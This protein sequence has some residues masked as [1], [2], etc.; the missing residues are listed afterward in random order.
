[1]NHRRVLVLGLGNVL[2]G[3]DGAG[4]AAVHRLLHEYELPDGVD[5]LDG[6]TLGMSLLAEVAEADELVIV[7]AVRADAAAGSL[8][9]L[10]GDEVVPAVTE[11]LS[12]HQVGVLDLLATAQFVG[13]YPQHVVVLGVVP[14]SMELGVGRT[15]EVDAAL[16]ALVAALVDELGARGFEL[17]RR[18]DTA[19][20]GRDHV[21]RV[22]GL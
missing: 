19:E 6:G 5:A 8:V 21:A 20:G 2:C 15:P 13:R 17:R 1:M 22:L 7:D 10:D 12:V 14:R 18:P 3:D 11:R 9:R 16:P 4:V